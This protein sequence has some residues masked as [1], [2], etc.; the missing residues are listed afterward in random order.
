MTCCIHLRSYCSETLTFWTRESLSSSLWKIIRTLKVQTKQEFLY[1][2]QREMTCHL[3]K[4]FIKNSIYMLAKFLF[5]WHWK[6]ITSWP[7][8]NSQVLLCFR[9]AKKEKL[10]ILLL[11]IYSI[12]TYYFYNIFTNTFTITAVIPGKIFLKHSENLTVPVILNTGI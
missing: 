3:T 5:S 4:C 11:I 8:H 2:L 7:A 1:F 12:F 6:E 9:D 10:L